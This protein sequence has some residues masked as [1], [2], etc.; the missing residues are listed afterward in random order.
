[1]QL[2]KRSSIVAGLFL[3]ISLCNAENQECKS[4]DNVKGSCRRGRSYPLVKGKENRSGDTHWADKS[5][6]FNSDAGY[7]T[8]IGAEPPTL[9]VLGTLGNLKV[10]P[11]QE[12]IY[13]VVVN[14]GSHYMYLTGLQKCDF[15]IHGTSLDGITAWA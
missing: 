4:C 7:S 2:L 8:D 9:A 1:M 13:E 10:N 15:A 5:Q 3:L 11:N 14:K 6:R 12:I